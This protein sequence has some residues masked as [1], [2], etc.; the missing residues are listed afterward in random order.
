MYVREARLSDLPH[1]ADFLRGFDVFSVPDDALAIAKLRMAHN[2]VMVDTRKLIGW[3]AFTPVDDSVLL[4]I[5]VRPDYHGKWARPGL[6]KALCEYA[7]T[8]LNKQ[9]IIAESLN[10]RLGKICLAA[11]FV[12]THT[13]ATGK[14]ISVLTRQNF[15]RKFARG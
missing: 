11:G 1:L 6:V 4:D 8:D 5:A 3:V 15:K 7:F 10:A 2:L 14:V 12:L 13:D 9:N